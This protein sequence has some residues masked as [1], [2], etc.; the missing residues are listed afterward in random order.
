[1]LQRLVAR[2][3]TEREIVNSSLRANHKAYTPHLARIGSGPPICV[4]SNP[5][6]TAYLFD[7][8]GRKIG[9]QQRD[10]LEDFYLAEERMKDFGAADAVPLADLKA[11]LGSDG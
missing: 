10:P 1:M 2:H 6:Y 7:A 9:T 4:G 8:D 3:L 5:R 11:A